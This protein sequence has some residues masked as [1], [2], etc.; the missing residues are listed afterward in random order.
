MTAEERESFYHSVDIQYIF[1]GPLERQLARARGE[2][3]PEWATNL[4][5][6]YDEAGYQIYEVVP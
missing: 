1:Y 3:S 5:L 6:I 2:D 4:R